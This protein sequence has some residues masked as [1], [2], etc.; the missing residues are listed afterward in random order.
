MLPERILTT[1]LRRTNRRY[2]AQ[3]PASL[4]RVP[5]P[6]PGKSYM[7]YAHVPFCERLCMYCSFNRFLFREDLAREYF[8]NLREEMRLVADLGYDF[9]SMYIGGGT[10]T[11]LMDE[12]FATIDFARELFGIKE[13][14]T[15]SS[16]NLLIDDRLDELSGRVQRLSV[17]VQSFNDTLLRQMDRYDKYGS[18][19]DVHRWIESVGG[20]FNS[21]NVDMIF[22]FPSQTEEILHRDIELVKSCGAN[23]VTFYPLMASKE[24]ARE[25]AGTVGAVD[26]DREA[27]YY[28]IVCRELS[29]MYEAS[30]AWTFSA[31]KDAMIDEYIVDYEEYVGVGSGAMSFLDGRIYGNTFSLREYGDAIAERRMAIVKASKPYA[32]RDLMRYRFVVDLFG[33]RLDKRRFERDFGVSADKGLALELGF[34]RTFD[35]IEHEDAEEV[36]LNEHGR[37][38]LVVMM[39]EMLIGSNDHRDEA[40]AALPAEER[41]LLLETPDESVKAG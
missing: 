2:L 23:Q 31:E 4:D 11:I 39:R 14:S 24:T 10:P 20:R 40:R 12:L 34:L 26:T 27:R 21:L 17:G 16:P 29:S 9:D 3:Y 25:L 8:R 30:S 32:K 36:T 19:A 37:Y 5:P 33:L 22:N 38:L 6:R 13:V 1:L 15:E 41:M 28:R 18:A 35:A 7:L